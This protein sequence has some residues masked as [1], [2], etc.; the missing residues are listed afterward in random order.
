MVI[1]IQTQVREN[2]GAHTWDGKGECPQYWKNKGGDN[3][4]ITNVPEGADVESLVDRAVRELK[5]HRDD[6]FYQEYVI[7]TEIHPDGYVSWSEQEEIDYYGRIIHTTP[8]I[9][10]DELSH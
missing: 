7:G 1:E 9:S 5:I 3:Y 4:L 2:Y 10:F 6:N 8:R